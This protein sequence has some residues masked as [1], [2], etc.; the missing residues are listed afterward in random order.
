MREAGGHNF[1]FVYI[2][3]SINSLGA[4]AAAAAAAAITFVR[5]EFSNSLLF[6][7]WTRVAD[8]AQTEL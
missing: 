8:G 7:R 1:S 5:D 2:R 4:A 6:L 3:I